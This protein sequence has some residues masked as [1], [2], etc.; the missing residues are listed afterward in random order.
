[1]ADLGQYFINGSRGK[2]SP[3]I[4]RS[5]VGIVIVQNITMGNVLIRRWLNT[6]TTPQD[7]RDLL[8]L[9]NDDAKDDILEEFITKSQNIILHYIQV[10]VIEEEISLDSSGKTIVLTNQFLADTNFDKLINT[11]DVT[12]YGY[13][14]EDSI[15]TRTTLSLSTIWPEN[16]ILKLSSDASSYGKVTVSYSYYTCSIDWNLVAMATAYYAGML[17]VAREEFLVPDELTI[18]N[19]KVRQ[20]QPWNKLREEFNRMIFHLTSVPMDLVNYRKMMVSPRSNVR[21]AGP[22]TIIGDVEDKETGSGTYQRDPEA[23]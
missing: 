6:Y 13:V 21:Y 7:I 2:D 20:K 17:W 1:L 5:C 8:G 23:E 9:T 15:E 19:I 18:G 3:K 14:D 4:F 16:G 10:K 22:G 12:V 11:L